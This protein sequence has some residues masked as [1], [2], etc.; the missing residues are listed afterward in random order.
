MQR[1]LKATATGLSFRGS[2]QSLRAAGVPEWSK[3]PDCKPGIRR[4]FE[5]DRQLHVVCHCRARRGCR[6]VG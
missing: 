2:L 4:R 6:Q 1:R 5:S 3:G